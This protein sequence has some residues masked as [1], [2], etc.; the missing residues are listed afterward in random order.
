ML[1][2]GTNK[3][4]NKMLSNVVLAEKLFVEYGGFIRSVL[5][6]NTRNELLSDDLFQDLFLFFVSKPI[7][8]EVQNV[9]G[10]LY[11][12]VSDKIKDALRRRERYQSRINRY[13]EYHSRTVESCPENVLIEEE[14][15]KKMF[16]LINKRLPSNEALAVTLRYR[17]NHDTK[18]I[19]DKM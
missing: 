5:N 15:V 9:K 14:E 2:Q 7:G 3:K 18:E 8:E 16:E 12:V 1:S 6:F 17:S 11:R 13:S 10:F 19:A 4:S